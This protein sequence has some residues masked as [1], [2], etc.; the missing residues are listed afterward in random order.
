MDAKQVLVLYDRERK[1][2]EIFG[3][4]REEAS[5]IVRHIS[6]DGGG[7]II[8]SNLNSAN[9]ERVIH[10][11]VSHFE[12]KGGDLRWIVYQHDT[13]ANLKDRLLVH[14]FEAQDPNAI[15]VLDIRHV[16]PRLL[17]PVQHDV[18][19]IEDPERIDD[20]ITIHQR[21]WHGSFRRSR[22]RLAKQLVDAPHSLCL[23]LAYV[24]GKPVSTAQV[25]FYG[26][27]PFAS[28]V[29]AATLPGYRGRGLFTALVTMALVPLNGIPILGQLVI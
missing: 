8:Y 21:V 2:V 23:Y 17:E 1:E 27:R 11:Q 25:S 20:V 29:R 5:H 16:S 4:Q 9:A 12:D 7:L 28:L 18:R 14:G 3:M 6:P 26:Q 24:D 19:R 15:L 13:P 10:E 22:T